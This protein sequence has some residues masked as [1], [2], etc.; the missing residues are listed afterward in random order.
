M[1][2]SKLKLSIMVGQA[3]ANDAIQVPRGRLHE[4]TQSDGG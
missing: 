2:L 3:E 4:Q 1:L